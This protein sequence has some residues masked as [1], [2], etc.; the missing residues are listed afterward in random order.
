MTR[1]T[2]ADAIRDASMAMPRETGGILVG[3]RTDASIR[4]IRAVE[5]PDPHATRWRYERRHGEAEALLKA[6]MAESNDPA[7]G[8][9]GEWHTHQA[10]L[11]HSL[12]DRRELRSISNLASHAVALVVLARRRRGWKVQAMTALAGTIGRAQVRDVR[13]SELNESKNP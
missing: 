5:V 7:V 8:Y 11:R 4:V 2:E 10:P 1:S 3:W 6:A 12:Q 9:V 13:A